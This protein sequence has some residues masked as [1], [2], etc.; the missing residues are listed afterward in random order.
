MSLH[1]NDGRKTKPCNAWAAWTRGGFL[2]LLV[3]LSTITIYH[4]KGVLTPFDNAMNDGGDNLRL[5][6]HNQEYYP[7]I[8]EQYI[9]SNLDRLGFN[10]PDNPDT[11]HIWS[12]PNATTLEVFNSLVAYKKDIDKYN[13]II[14]N[15]KPV[16]SIMDK[17]R[18]EGVGVEEKSKIC[19]SLRLHRDGMQGIF[20]SKQLSFTSSGYVEPLLPPMRSHK[21]CDDFGRNLMSLE[22]L[23]HDFEVMCRKLKPTSRLVLLDMGAALDFHGTNQP[24]VTLLRQYEKFG[25]VFDHIY[26]FEINEKNPKEVYETSLPEDYISSYHWINVGVSAKEGDKLNPLHSIIKKFNEDDFVVVKLDIDTSS[27]EVPLAHQLLEDKDGIY[28][29]IIDQFYFE[30]HV[31]LG[32][33]KNAWRWTMN[34]TVGESLELFSN[35]RKKGVPAH[36]WP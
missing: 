33:L 31:H 11:C 29:K 4:T 36:F 16:P 26:G 20:P 27:I 3:L 32:E 22:Y 24:I 8:A 35:L 17:I 2:L 9:V 21:I 1:R 10:E 34:G 18:Q 23:V 7:G 5:V 25:F 6:G 12:D 13:E 14:M 15:F 28:S 30:H 19:D